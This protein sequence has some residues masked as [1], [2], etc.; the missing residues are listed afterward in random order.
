MTDI[1]PDSLDQRYSMKLLNK[2]LT[3]AQRINPV[4]QA[5]TDHY[6]RLLVFQLNLEGQN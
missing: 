2:E 5:A 3:D 4:L 6:P 1:L